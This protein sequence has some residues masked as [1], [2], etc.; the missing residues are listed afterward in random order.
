MWRMG[1]TEIPTNLYIYLQ[2]LY[3]AKEKRKGLKS[4][5]SQI[6]KEI[7]EYQKLIDIE[8]LNMFEEE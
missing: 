2:R 7:A 8:L 4:Q 3:G 5:Q 1:M 6:D